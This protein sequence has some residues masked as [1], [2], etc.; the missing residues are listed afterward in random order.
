MTDPMRR[1][2]ML[3]AIGVL[4][5]LL[6]AG[7]L[8]LLDRRPIGLANHVR[9][10]VFIACLC[11]AGGLWLLAGAIVRR[12]ALPLRTIWLVLGVAVA[13]WLLILTAPPI[14]LSDIYRY[15]RDGRVQLA[16]INPYR[17][18]PVDDALAFLR[19]EDVYPHI[20][21]ADY[22]HTLYPP[23]GQAIFALAAV[24]YAEPDW[25]VVAREP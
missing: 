17:Y 4:L 7:G 13:M 22:A 15:V 20:N 12:G 8:A 18:L 1:L 5:V 16:G 25:A 23:A 2:A 10:A 21:R 6:I 11:L 24:H 3:A 9:L 14:L 19:D